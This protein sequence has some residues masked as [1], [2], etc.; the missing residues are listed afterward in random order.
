MRKIKNY[1]TPKIFIA[2]G[3]FK[4]YTLSALKFQE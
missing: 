2:R 4:V 1:T 3:M